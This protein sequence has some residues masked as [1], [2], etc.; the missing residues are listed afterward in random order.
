MSIWIIWTRFQSCS[1]E[2]CTYCCTIQ[3]KYK[4]TCTVRYNT[5]QV[6]LLLYDTIIK[7]WLNREKHLPKMYKMQFQGRS[8]LRFSCASGANNQPHQFSRMD[9]RCI[10]ATSETI[11]NI[12]KKFV[13]KLFQA[14]RK[15]FI[16]TPPFIIY[17][18]LYITAIQESYKIFQSQ[19]IFK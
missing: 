3:Y 14:I 7:I 17:Y 11:L 1:V 10:I 12:V 8:V 13:R 6:H 9:A 15:F 4:C 18:I 2:L 5:V 16:C 19:K